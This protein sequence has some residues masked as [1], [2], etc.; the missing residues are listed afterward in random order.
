MIQDDE[1]LQ[2]F[3][4]ESSEHLADVESQLLQIEEHGADVDAELVNT[5]FRAVHSVKGAAGFLG[6]TSINEL[7]HNLEN[8]LN[9]IRNLELVPSHANVDVLLRSSD[10]LVSLLQDVNNSNSADVSDQVAEL[11]KVFDGEGGAGEEEPASDAGD[12]SA[13][14]AE[15][16]TQEEAIAEQVTDVSST[17]SGAIDDPAPALAVAEAS[18]AAPSAQTAPP[19]P[20]PVPPVA[21]SSSPATSSKTG[22]A[23]D[24]KTATKQPESNVRVN[25]SIL[26]RLMN[27]AGELVLGRNQLL[28]SLNTSSREQLE[29]VAA[30]LDHVT[31]ELQEAIMQTRM[32]PVGSV[33]NRFPRVV[34]DLTSK[35]GKKC[36]LE[37]EGSEVEVDKTIIEA[38]GDPL[39]HLVR[40]SVDHGIESPQDRVAAGKP[41]E[42]ANLPSRVPSSRQGVYSHRR[43]WWRN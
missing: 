38:I 10:R 40:N 21:T 3:V 31:G 30:R 13:V 8:V 34:R 6:L 26:D 4:I 14:A 25:V 7:A 43:Q 5:V 32:Q 12:E 19:Q 37:I 9:K 16:A 35:L 39:T 27:L 33:F 1:L 36:S 20:A 29:T 28:Q 15:S 22:G 18:V 42:G 41:A 2:E 23:R 11:Q 17:V 24:A